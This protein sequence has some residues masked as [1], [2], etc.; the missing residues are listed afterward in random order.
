[1]FQSEC[2]YES[3]RSIIVY[4]IN[5]YLHV[6]RTFIVIRLW[7]RKVDIFVFNVNDSIVGAKDTIMDFEVDDR[8]AIANHTF[9]GEGAFTSGGNFE[10]RYFSDGTDTYFELDR[11][12]DG[13]VDERID[14]ATTSDWT[15]TS[16]G[17]EITGVINGPAEGDFG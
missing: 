4:S 16:D 11:N 6:S 7:S 8:I 17:Q 14:L 10:V 5:F 12:G 13:T 1:M 15:F 2:V 3:V 9:V